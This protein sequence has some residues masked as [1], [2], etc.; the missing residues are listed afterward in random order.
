MSQTRRSLLAAIGA[1]LL[2]GCAGSV[3]GES[4][5]GGGETSTPTPEPTPKPTPST[6]PPTGGGPL[7]MPRSAETVAENITGVVGQDSIP[8]IDEPKMVAADEM[9]MDDGEIVFGLAR[10][11]VARAYPQRILVWHEIAND[12]VGGEPLTISYCPLTG[13]AMGFRR[14]DTTFGVSGNLVNS[15]LV[16]YDRETESLWPQMLATAVKGDMTGEVLR[17]FRLVWTT[18]GAWREAHPETEVLS[19]RTGYSRNYGRDPYGSYN[20]RG[21]YYVGNSTMFSVMHRD[22]SLTAKRMVLGSR[23]ADA[24]VAFDRKLLRD[25]GVLTATV[26]GD[27]RVAVHDPGLDVGYVY[28]NPDGATVERADG[29]ARVDGETHAA[30]EL[31][32]DRRYAYAAMWFAWAA[33]YPDTELIA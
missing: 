15:N 3:P 24:A 6:T 23:T 5:G 33:Y 1:G 21:G 13:T 12:V 31:P 25:E 14:G 26:D 20:P 2:A 8:A 10:N 11:G 30:A 32:L 16:M 7:Y 22:G 27:E 29:G 18:W 19:E 9:E 4:G 17:E 28:D